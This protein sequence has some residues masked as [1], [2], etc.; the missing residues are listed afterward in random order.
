MSKKILTNTDF[1]Q[2]QLLKAVIENLSSAPGTPQV[3]QVY[4]D[5]TIQKFGVYTSTGWLYSADNNLDVIGIVVD[6]GGSVLTV[7][8]KGTRYIPFD[9]TI[10]GFDLRSDIS[11]S[12]V[13]DVKVGGVSIAGTE[14]P[15]LAGASSA[16]DMALS[17]WSVDLNAGDVV[18]FI[19]DSVATIK[20]ATLSVIIT[21]V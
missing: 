7:G 16:S 8:S 14:K 20:R 15:T 1:N 12:V 3:G 9:C 18:E 5:T 4:F 19:I 11:G 21:R 6:G 10:T 2:N 17:T 13:F